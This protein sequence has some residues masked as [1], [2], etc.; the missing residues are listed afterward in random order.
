MAQ[1]PPGFRYQRLSNGGVALVADQSFP[2]QRASGLAFQRTH[3]LQPAAPG[4][5]QGL[6][7]HPQEH[8]ESEHYPGF[9]EIP[10]FYTVSILLPGADDSIAGESTPIRPEPF[11]AR[12]ITWATSGDAPTFITVPSIV[13]SA[14]GRCVEVT[15]EDE[16]TKFLGNQPCLVSALF[17]D[18][19]GFLDFPKKGI[20]FQGRQ[21][22]SVKLHRLLWPDPDSTPADTRW[23]FNFQGVSLLPAN[24]NQSGSAG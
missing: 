17:G 19:Q 22:L 16:F 4:Q 15:W 13:G 9:I 23:D 7:Q 8:E 18:S 11:V 14:Q 10:A 5:V 20:L 24:I 2:I 12:R 21:V 6:G 1:P 3:G